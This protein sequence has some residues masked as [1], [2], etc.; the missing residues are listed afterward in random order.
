M[1]SLRV[2]F[3]LAVPILKAWV[4]CYVPEAF[5][6]G[7][8]DGT[9]YF[10][11]LA[12]H[13][14]MSYTALV[15][16]QVKYL[17]NYF[18]GASLSLLP[19]IAPYAGWS[20]KTAFNSLWYDVLLLITC[21]SWV[22]WHINHCRLL[23]F[24][25]INSSISNNPVEST[26]FVYT[27]LNVKRVPFQT[28]QF[29]INTVSVS[30]KKILFQTIQFIIQKTVPFQTIQFRISTQFKCQNSCISSNSV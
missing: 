14:R 10:F 8:A 27:Q 25:H 21:Q 20:F 19:F 23:I 15:G 2:P 11:G 24:I 3:S 22:L 17:L 18:P 28:I 1:S 6:K 13:D 12:K 9:N 30:K 29:S 16:S 7:N 5:Q 4:Y 26:N